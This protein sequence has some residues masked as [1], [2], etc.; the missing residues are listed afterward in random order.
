MSKV[1]GW[2]VLIGSVICFIVQFS[3]Q[4]IAA[5]ADPFPADNRPFAAM[6]PDSETADAAD[7]IDY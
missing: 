5:A 1:F 6:Q 3:T 4:Q 2:I 7:L